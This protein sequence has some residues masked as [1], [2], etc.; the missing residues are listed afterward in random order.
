[1]PGTMLFVS[2]ASRPLDAE[3]SGA[4]DTHRTRV[5]NRLWET[6]GC[7]GHCIPQMP[8]PIAPLNNYPHRP[9]RTRNALPQRVPLAR[10]HQVDQ[11]VFP[12]AEEITSA[13]IVSASSTI[14]EL[15]RSLNTSAFIGTNPKAYFPIARH[16]AARAWTFVSI[17]F[18]LAFRCRRDGTRVLTQSS[19]HEPSYLGHEVILFRDARCPA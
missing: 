16:P 11:V 2:V 4:R 6:N 7:A 18:A 19:L 10:K 1:M 14:Q 15:A 5:W 17:R 9:R 13:R 3:R 8:I 12:E